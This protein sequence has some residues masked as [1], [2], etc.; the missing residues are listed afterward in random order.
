MVDLR[1]FRSMSMFYH[2]YYIEA[3]LKVLKMISVFLLNDVARKHLQKILMKCLL[4]ILLSDV[5]TCDII[6]E[7]LPKVFLKVL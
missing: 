3:V 4:K 5:S 1:T 2:A 7:D 6:S